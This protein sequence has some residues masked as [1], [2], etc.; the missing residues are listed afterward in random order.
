MEISHKNFIF[1]APDASTP[2][3]WNP[4]EVVGMAA[5]LWTRSGL[6]RSWNLALFEQEVLRSVQL[7]QF[8]LATHKGQPAAFLSWGHLSDAAEVAYLTDPHSLQAQDLK[9][10]PHLW[11]LNWAAPAGGTPEF[12]WV[13]RHVLFHS[14]VGHMLRVKP[15]QHETARLVSAKGIHVPTQA[16]V[17]EIQRVHGSHLR[18]QALRRERIPQSPAPLSST[19]NAPT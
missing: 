9:S 10:G 16:Y 18:A 8:I 2:L 14:S 11:L 1:Y 17:Q 15:M 12:T 3:A 19:T 5:W 6:H 13:A 7:N 4:W